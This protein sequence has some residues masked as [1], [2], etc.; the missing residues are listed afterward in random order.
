MV[1]SVRSSPALWASPLW[2]CFCSSAVE[3]S[4]GLQMALQGGG[5]DGPFPGQCA[6]DKD[7]A[8]QTML[9]CLQLAQGLPCWQQCWLAHINVMGL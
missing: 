8:L 5:D 9:P 2:P 3:G 6:V 7:T 1:L 4:D